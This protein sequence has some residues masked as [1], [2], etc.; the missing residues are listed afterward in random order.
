MTEDETRNKLNLLRDQLYFLY[1][2]FKKINSQID[3]TKKE[4]KNVLKN[5]PKCYSC[6]KNQ[7]PKYMFIATQEELDS[8]T[9]SNEGY[10]G[11][12]IGEYYCGC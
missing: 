6:G 2:E 4:I 1:S 8:Y 7:D 3:D 9:D 11:P 10:N 5:F 12:K